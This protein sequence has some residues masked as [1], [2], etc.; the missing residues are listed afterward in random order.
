MGVPA[1]YRWISEKYS[2]IVVDILERRAKVVDGH[3][4]PLNLQEANPNSIEFDNLYVDMNGLIHPC[5]HPEDREAPR[6]EEEMYANVVKYVDRL[7]AAIRP[8]KILFLAID[9]V[10]PR[11]KMNQQRSRRFRAA[12]EAKEK[13]EMMKEVMQEMAE[14]GFEL[15]S[16]ENDGSGSGP[17]HGEWDSNVITPGTDF[18][19]KISNFLRFYLLERMNN[20]PYWASLQIILSDASE[21]GEGEHKIMDFIRSQRAQPGYNPN[22]HH[23]LHGLDADLIMLALAT[24]EVKFTILREK[25]F[26]GRKEKEGEA[27]LSDAQKLL[28]AESMRNGA[29]ISSL[30]PEDE[31][32]YSKP[33]QALHVYILREYLENEFTSLRFLLPFEYDLERIIDDFIFLC[34]FVGND[35]LPHLP[36]L[37]IRDGALD[38]LMECYKEILPSLGNYLTSPGGYINLTQADVLL[39]RVGEI[40]DQIFLRRKQAED[41]FERKMESRQAHNN[42]NKG[43]N[44]PAL[45]PPPPPQQSTNGKQSNPSN[46]DNSKAAEAIREKLLGNKRI[47]E[48]ISEKVV[49]EVVTTDTSSK[50]VRRES[51]ESLGGE[52]EWDSEE[53]EV[54][55]EVVVKPIL[56]KVV[57]PKK[58]AISEEDL[59]KA[60]AE[61]KNRIKSKESEMFDIYK[62]TVSDN[63]K[64]HEAGWKD[65]YYNEPHKKE[66]VERGG[67]IKRMCITYVQGLCWVLRYYY[68]GVPSWNWYYPFHYAPFASDLVNIDTYGEMVFEKSQPFRP[69]E[70]LL[71]VLPASSAGALPPEVRWLMLDKE[72]PIID[73]YNDDVPIDPNG[74]HLPWLWILLLPFVDE[75][76]IT[77][78]FEG[79][80]P[81]LTL[82]SRKK[83]IFGKSVL[84]VHEKHRLGRNAISNNAYGQSAEDDDEI[85]QLVGENH[86]RNDEGNTA[87]IY[88]FECP[89]ANNL[90]GTIKRSSAKWFAPLH[91]T[92]S[93]PL[94]SSRWLKEI[95]HNRVICCEYQIPSINQHESK[96][97]EGAIAPPSSLHSTDLLPKRPPRLNKSGFNVLDLYHNSKNMRQQQLHHGGRSGGS[98]QAQSQQQYQQ[99]HQQSY[100]YGSGFQERGYN[101][102]TADGYHGYHHQGAAAYMQDMPYSRQQQPPRGAAAYAP[103]YPFPVAPQLQQVQRN[104]PQS[105]QNSGYQPQPQ[106]QY[107]Q[108]QS[109][110][111]FIHQAPPSAADHRIQ[112]LW[113][114]N[115]RPIQHNVLPRHASRDGKI[116]VL[117]N[118][119]GAPPPSSSYGFGGGHGFPAGNTRP[120]AMFNTQQQSLP[121]SGPSSLQ[122]MRQQLLQTH[123]RRQSDHQN[124]PGN[125]NNYQPH[126]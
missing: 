17:S 19:T 60:K 74:K 112:P 55:E 103:S 77:D 48:E 43:Q 68:Q 80:K 16:D 86:V 38:F 14:S 70:Q 27:Q 1:F 89:A 23:V 102:T 24:H 122:D 6:T 62:K 50:K 35:F 84:F 94:N 100:G 73:L 125:R 97:L 54:L 59:N 88:H 32:I 106:Q 126:R 75:T 37:D 105:Y 118:V 64:L 21:P 42:R 117:D 66:D 7:V 8:R 49:D 107:Q 28:N 11:A 98:Y 108:V 93:P 81:T 39:S 95:G 110:Q 116:R 45:P 72:S 121:P 9:G 25:V 5:S 52:D 51:S 114:P 69:I 41:N 120:S 56:E 113:N 101:Y 79:C 22:T 83:N 53:E 119:P 20:D 47:R 115:S 109:Q 13:R 85:L 67:G 99:R 65:R 3:V 124:P 104:A 123:N 111:R 2:K 46:A 87:V 58:A 40:E 90:S 82:E 29:L 31:W 71:A 57:K 92:I 63:V 36:S 10:A 61:L 96:L 30:R 76:R 78:A 4:E 34:F 44:T 12:Q 33:L 91:E 15:E 18:M 26:F